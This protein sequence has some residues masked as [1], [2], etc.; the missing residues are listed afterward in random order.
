MLDFLLSDE[1][2]QT[3]SMMIDKSAHVMVTC[4]VSPDGDALGSMLAFYH[5]L[6]R[7]G[8]KVTAVTPNIFPEF[9][10]WMPGADEILTFDKQ[11]DEVKAAISDVNLV[12]CL[13]FNSPERLEELTET[14]VALDVPMIMIDH[15]PFPATERFSLSISHPEMCATCELL[16]R[17]LVALYGEDML[18]YDEAVCL[19]TGMMTDTGAFTYNSSRSDIY[20]IIGKL[21]EKG[22]DKDKIHQIAGYKLDVKKDAGQRRECCCVESIDI[23]AYD[24]CTGGCK[25]CYAVH[26]LESA[27]KKFQQHDPESPLLIGDLRGDEVVTDKEMHSLR[28]NQISLFDLPEMI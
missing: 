22:I 8:K 3:L 25:Y 5:F 27:K 23:G 15:H 4:H 11:A 2:S 13:D 26:S 14:V 1:E 28:D 9:L 16:Y 7:R 17:V 6:H 24:T 10:K 19:Y 18:G 20:Y 21:L 12:V